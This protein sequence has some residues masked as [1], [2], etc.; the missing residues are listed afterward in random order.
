LADGIALGGHNKV[1]GEFAA[2][3]CARFPSLERVRFCNSGTEANLFAMVAARTFTG[4]NKIMVMQGGYH[5]GVFYFSGE[6]S[7]INA[8]FAYVKARYNDAEGV[9]K[10]IELHAKDLAAVIVEPMMGG[11]GCIAADPEFL[12]VL[13]AATARHG[14]LLIFDEVMT[15]RLTPSGLQG[16]H[17]I[18]P[19]LTTLGKYIGG[20]LTFGGFGGR[21]DIMD[22][23]DPRRADAWP[24]AGT[25]NNN[26][27]TMSA[28]AAGLRDVYT[29]DVAIAFNARG[30]R[31]RD[32]LNAAATRRG[33]PAQFTGLGSMMTVHVLR[34]AI[35]SPDDLAR[36]DKRWADLFH[37]D[38]MGRGYYLARRGM[39]T[40]SLPMTDADL[41]GF[42]G[43]VEEWFDERR[44]L[45]AAGA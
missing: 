21:A 1:E 34:G 26:I 44:D 29:A 16:K 17:G 18:T 36:K 19:D 27:L 38:M 3:V 20:G 25:F 39:I 42:V 8:P 15:S 41:D 35:R 14:A 33:L 40:L 24:H 13:R 7:P 6:G 4:R 28:G 37:L 23:F 32:R 30:D 9:T 45:I 43:A 12:R 5:G 31:L 2:L 11:G 10:L 22:R